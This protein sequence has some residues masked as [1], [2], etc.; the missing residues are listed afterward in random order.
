MMEWTKTRRRQPG[1]TQRIERL[2]F[3]HEEWPGDGVKTEGV[4][5]LLDEPR[6]LAPDL[7]H[8]GLRH[9]FLLQ[10]AYPKFNMGMRRKS[11]KERRC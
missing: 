7:D 6:R 3:Q 2:V 8:E 10:L 4:A 9:G 5:F 11:D 1:M